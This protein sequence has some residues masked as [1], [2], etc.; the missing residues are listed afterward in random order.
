M[1]CGCGDKCNLVCVELADG[2]LFQV[3]QKGGKIWQMA[4]PSLALTQVAD[5]A[6]ATALIATGTE[7]ACEK[8]DAAIAAAT[9][10]PDYEMKT[11][12]VL[13]ADGLPTDT[14]VT[15]FKYV[16]QV[17]GDVVTQFFDMAGAAWTGDPATLGLC[18]SDYEYQP[19]DMF[20]VLADGS[21]VDFTRLNQTVNEQSTGVFIDIGTD[22]QPYTVVDAAN[23]GKGTCAAK[24]V[25]TEHMTCVREVD[26]AGVPVPFVNSQQAI[27]ETTTNPDDS[28]TL[29]YLDTS[30][31]PVVEFAMYDS[32]AFVAPM[33]VADPKCS[34]C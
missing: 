2:T 21:C 32:G 16:D 6:A 3:F 7:V 4:I 30:V 14:E 15:V 9:E 34:G 26:S 27:L 25:V 23:I 1:S 12:C 33:Y 29:R 17:S 11:R 24:T 19:V 18:E 5:A 20:E 31:S 22:G 10:T 8:C 13:D 28:K